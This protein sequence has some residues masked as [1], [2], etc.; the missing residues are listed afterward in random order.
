MTANWKNVVIS[1]EMSIKGALAVIDKEA[2]RIALVVSN[3]KL[4][5]TITDGDIRRGILKGVGLDEAVTLVMNNNPFSL[6]SE[7][8]ATTVKRLMQE[9]N[10]LSVPLVDQN[11]VLVGLRTLNETLSV[12]KKENPVFI[13]AGGFGTRLR[14]LTDNCPKPMLKVGG[15]PM[16]EILI[17]N[18]KKH[19][20]YKFYI[21]TH[22]LPEV[23]E[24]YFGNGEN[25]DVDIEYV[26]EE[27]PLGTAGALSLLP[28]NIPNLPLIMINGD[29]LTNVDFS[30]VLG[31]HLKNK[32]DATMCVRDYEIQVPFGVVEGLGHEITG[33]VEKPTYRYFVNAGI[34]IVSN[35]I[36]KSLPKNERL[37]MP[38]LFEIK[39]K[40]KFT[41]L[42]FPV[43]E[44]WLDVGRHAD[45]DKAQTDVFELGLL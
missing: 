28:D 3:N 33:I 1:E 31:F 17:E 12:E 22:Y 37:D 20:F 29:I 18:F 36:I 41:V 9:K 8:D 42:K 27:N 43:H 11:G 32:S 34:Y 10:I 25:F 45:F 2:L 5:G 26:Y 44:Y 23:I 24:E 21:S 39:K 30:K 6:T 13:M 35:E 38:N 16:L 4:I 15:R 19:G 40:D 7:I 14:P